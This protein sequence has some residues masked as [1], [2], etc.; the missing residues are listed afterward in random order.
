MI[1]PD[2]KP[3]MWGNWA[4]GN[5]GVYYVDWARG[6][7]QSWLAYRDPAE[8]V[9]RRIRALAKQPMLWDAGLAVSPDES[10]IYSAQFVTGTSEV[11]LLARF[12]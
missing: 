3:E 8:A 5:R 9:P 4:P 10:A 2:L 6:S 1:V 12:R 7:M 11:F